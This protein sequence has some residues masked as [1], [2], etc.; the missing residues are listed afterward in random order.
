MI[1]RKVGR[2]KKNILYQGNEVMVHEFIDMQ[3][4]G[5][6]SEIKWVKADLA[7]AVW[8]RELLKDIC[9]IRVEWIL[10]ERINC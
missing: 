1:R 3:G 9:R 6:T 4:S 8:M 5:D 2:T 10:H 7:P